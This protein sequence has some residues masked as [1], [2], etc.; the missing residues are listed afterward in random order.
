MIV[1]LEPSTTTAVERDAPYSVEWVSKDRSVSEIPASC[2][3]KKLMRML[4]KTA[5]ADDDNIPYETFASHM[6][7]DN[8]LIR[9][10]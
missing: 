9:M 6:L 5:R 4:S 10:L 8:E 1:L 7:T 2:A 3:E